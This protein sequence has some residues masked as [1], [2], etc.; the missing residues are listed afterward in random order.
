MFGNFIYFIVALLIYSTYQPP[1]TPQLSLP[2]SLFLLSGL[3]FGYGLLTRWHFRKIERM[4]STTP[5]PLL[6]HRFSSALTH[7]SILAVVAFGISIYGLNLPAHTHAIT[8]FEKLPTLEGLLYMALFIG[9]LVVMWNLAYATLRRVLSE[10]LSRKEY[11]NSH[12]MFNLPALLPW[13]IL[14]GIVDFIYILPFPSLHRI[15][16]TPLVGRWP[17]FSSFY[18]L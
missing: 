1:Q 3:I 17:I 9:M 11:V 4:S 6:D 5:L 13:L 16:A 18:S 2:H 8:L 10:E 14:S 12:L 15:I 7:S